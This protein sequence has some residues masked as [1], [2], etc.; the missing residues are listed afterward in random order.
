MTHT[1][2]LVIQDG[3]TA[4]DKAREGQ[5]DFAGDKYNETKYEELVKY[6]EEIGK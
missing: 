6:L 4:L 1:A 2:V 3:K 5:N